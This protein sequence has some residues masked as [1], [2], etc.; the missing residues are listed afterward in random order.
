MAVMVSCRTDAARAWQ[1]YVH[2]RGEEVLRILDLRR[3]ELSLSLVDDAEIRVLNATYRG[4]DRPTDVLAFALTEDA[5]PDV[6]RL[7][8]ASR[9]PVVLG[10]VVISMDTAAAQA[11]A[12]RRSLDVRLD[13]L[14]IHGVLHLVGYDHERSPAEER[15]MQAKERAVRAA[16]EKIRAVPGARAKVRAV[17]AAR[18][19]PAPGHTRRR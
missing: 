12:S 11:R 17:P 5:A 2:G 16:L 4:R 19:K 3:H 13:A 6:P 15:R 18:A 7:A 9:G 8:V 10:D 14:L 1:A